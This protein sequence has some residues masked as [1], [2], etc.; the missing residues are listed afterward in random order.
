MN[1]RELEVSEK[2]KERIG[3]RCCE[4]STGFVRIPTDIKRAYEKETGVV[5]KNRVSLNILTIYNKIYEIR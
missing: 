3:I 1:T 4:S 5:D 2:L